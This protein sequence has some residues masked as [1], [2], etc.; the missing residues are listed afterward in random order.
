[1][2]IC[3]QCRGSIPI[4]ICCHSWVHVNKWFYHAQN[5]LACPG[6]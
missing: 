5:V 4:L 2:L 6:K 1:L 3:C